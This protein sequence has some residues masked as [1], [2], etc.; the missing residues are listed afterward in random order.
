M[1]PG[2]TMPF[3]LGNKQ[4]RLTFISVFGS[5]LL[6]MERKMEPVMSS[7]GT[8]GRGCKLGYNRL[9]RNRR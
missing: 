5:V 6:E 8:R 3:I 2:E 9:Q 7:D 4:H 1:E